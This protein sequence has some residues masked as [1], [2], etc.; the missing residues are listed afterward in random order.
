[1]NTLNKFNVV[2]KHL[3][4]EEPYNKLGKEIIQCMCKDAAEGIILQ[5]G[6]E[7]G[8]PKVM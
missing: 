5:C 8:F 3:P 7:C 1:M 2:Y 4:I 6:R